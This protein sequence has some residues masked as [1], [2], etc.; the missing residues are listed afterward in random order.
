MYPHPFVASIATDFAQTL[1][2]YCEQIQIAGSLRRLCTFVKDVD[3]IAIPKFIDGKDDTLFGEPVKENL[4]DKKLFEMYLAKEITLETNGE[5]IKRFNKTV[6]GKNIPI[7]IYIAD[8]STWNTLLLI[9]T[10]SKRGK[11]NLDGSSVSDAQKN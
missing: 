9:R 3:I 5:K 4:L 11:E 10:E 1:V 8:L 7:D 2:P 6:Q